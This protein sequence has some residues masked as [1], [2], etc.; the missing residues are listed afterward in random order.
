MSLENEAK[1]ERDWNWHLGFTAKCDQGE[2]R[3]SVYSPPMGWNDLH[4]RAEVYIKDKKHLVSEVEFC[5]PGWG[6]WTAYHTRQAL[7]IFMDHLRVIDAK[8][9]GVRLLEHMDKDLKKFSL[10]QWYFEFLT[11]LDKEQTLSFERSWEMAQG[12]DL[13]KITVEQGWSIVL[14]VRWPNIWHGATEI[15]EI[16]MRFYA[17][18][19]RHDG[20][21]KI[22]AA[23]LVDLLDIWYW[24]DSDNK[25]KPLPKKN[26][27]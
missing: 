11:P 10:E 14:T 21:I 6:G 7:G 25:R 5:S 20:S 15:N 13:L 27:L 23:L 12:K 1:I 19:Q 16:S 17:T 18:G 4:I 9:T 26:F 3:L 8:S 22:H 24:M 2:V